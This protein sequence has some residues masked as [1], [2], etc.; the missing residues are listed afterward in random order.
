MHM[1]GTVT[2]IRLG[3]VRGEPLKMYATLEVE[4][5]PENNLEEK[6]LREMEVGD[7]LEVPG[8]EL[9]VEETE[10]PEETS[11]KN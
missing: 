4:M 6:H 8:I 7:G 5:H 1:K 9:A 2:K 3:S 10:E 11:N